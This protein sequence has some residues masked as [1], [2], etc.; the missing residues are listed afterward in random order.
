MDLQVSDGGG[1]PSVNDKEPS[2]RSTGDMLAFASDR[3][4]SLGDGTRDFNIWTMSQAGE[5][6]GGPAP[7][8]KSNLNVADTEDDDDPAWSPVD[9]NSPPPAPPRGSLRNCTPQ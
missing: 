9:L 5:A 4:Q 3:P 1:D 6:G 7:T 2:W 8:L